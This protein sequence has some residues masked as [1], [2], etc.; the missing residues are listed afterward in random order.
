MI[1]SLDSQVMLHIVYYTRVLAVYAPDTVHIRICNFWTVYVH[2]ELK[3]FVLVC[4]NLHQFQLITVIRSAFC[5]NTAF[6]CMNL[7][8]K[9]GMCKF[10]RSCF[11]ILYSIVA[12]SWQSYVTS[13]R[14]SD[15]QFLLSTFCPVLIFSIVCTWS[16]A[17]GIAQYH[18]SAVFLFCLPLFAFWLHD[19][20][21][22]FRCIYLR[23]RRSYV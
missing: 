13:S 8:V 6:S 22:S 2:S 10:W 4:L 17:F 23:P 20:L 16:S 14:L 3:G 19:I 15:H 11:G 18:A 21:L 12:W 1:L 5:S 9:F 7:S